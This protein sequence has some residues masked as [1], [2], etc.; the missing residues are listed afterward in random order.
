ME[1]SRDRI[2]V[3]LGRAL[4]SYRGEDEGD[5]LLRQLEP[6]I[7]LPWPF[8]DVTRP[9]TASPRNA[10]DRAE[11]AVRASL[12]SFTTELL[13]VLRGAMAA[14]VI[15]EAIEWNSLT[16]SR[17]SVPVPFIRIPAEPM[18]WENPEVGLFR[19]EPREREN[20]L[21]NIITERGTS[22]Q[23]RNVRLTPGSLGGGRV[24][25]SALTRHHFDPQLPP[26][27]RWIDLVTL[28]ES[29]QQGGPVTAL[30]TWTPAAIVNDLG[31]MIRGQIHC[32]SEDVPEEWRV[33]AWRP[34]WVL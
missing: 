26:S 5:A 21:W 24:M 8:D 19:A 18:R 28:E 4:R 30:V 6:W 29:T 25:L 32:W 20:L 13:A 34:R 1:L 3:E 33:Q 9:A 11:D 23:R 12:S 17:D 22:L 16:V 10:L 27:A 14:C 15:A 7:G 31:P 2:L